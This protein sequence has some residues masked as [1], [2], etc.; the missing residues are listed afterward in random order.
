MRV[1]WFNILGLGANVPFETA[2]QS[3]SLHALVGGQIIELHVPYP[4]GFFAQGLEGRIDDRNAGWKGRELWVTSGNLTPFHIEGSTHG[5][6][7]AGGGAGD[8]VEPARRRIPAPPRRR[9]ASRGVR[10][11][12]RHHRF[13]ALTDRSRADI[14]RHKC[15]LHRGRT[16]RSMRELAACPNVAVK[17]S[18]RRPPGQT[19]HAGPPYARDTALSHQLGSALFCCEDLGLG[20]FALYTVIAAPVPEG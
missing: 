7:R 3:D 12:L 10:R 1:D 17:I 19:G 6:P 18:G 5:P 9:A 4:M 14:D 8:L 16:A 13:E 20:D 2:N 11:D 15:H